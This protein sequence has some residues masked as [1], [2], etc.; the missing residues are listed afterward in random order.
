MIDTHTYGTSLTFDG[1]I[2]KSATFKKGNE[3]R[4]LWKRIEHLSPNEM[5]I[6]ADRFDSLCAIACE[7][8]LAQ[9]IEDASEIVIP[10]RTQYVRTILSEINRLVWLTTYLGRVIGSFG[11]RTM[12]QQIFV[13]REQ[14]FT[15][16]EELTGGR[17]LPQALAVGG[18]RRDL[19]LGNIQKIQN[20]TKEWSELWKV[21]RDLVTGDDLLESRLIGLIKID[22]VTIEKLGWWGVVGKA[23]GVSYDSRRHRPYG[24]YPYLDFNLISKTEGD[25]KSRFEVA[26]E[27]VELT[28]KLVNQII[29]DIPE[30]IDTPPS[31]T[32]P[33]ALRSGFYSSS[34]ESAKGPIISCLEVSDKNIITTVRLFSAGQRVWPVI[35]HL[36]K[37]IRGEDFEPAFASLGIT[38]EDSEI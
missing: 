13:L 19:P 31:T 38:P 2:L 33:R 32:P 15:I 29:K 1:D 7:W 21:W 25:A 22:T 14:V 16:Q 10:K 26:I 18:V 24:A 30:Q 20:F 34:V 28:L 35:E 23:S 3:E 37:D 9:A 8:A 11:Q 27:E 5:I 36:F 12:H 4:P 17:I 6:W